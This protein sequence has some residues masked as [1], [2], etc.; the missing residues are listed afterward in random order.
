MLIRSESSAFSALDAKEGWI[1]RTPA[2]ELMLCIYFYTF[3][4]TLLQV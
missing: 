3:V 4:I 2:A 1:I